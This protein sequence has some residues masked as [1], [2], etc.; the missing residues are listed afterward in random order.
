LAKCRR[1]EEVEASYHLIHFNIL[2]HFQIY[3]IILETL[4]KKKKALA[5]KNVVQSLQT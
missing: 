5:Y 4:I 3:Q 1:K 2:Y